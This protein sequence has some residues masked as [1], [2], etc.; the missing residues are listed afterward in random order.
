MSF[1]LSR[2]GTSRATA[3][4]AALFAL[5]LH[6]FAA[7]FEARHHWLGNKLCPTESLAS[8]YEPVDMELALDLLFTFAVCPLPI[9]LLALSVEFA[10]PACRLAYFSFLLG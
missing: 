6:H 5:P 4:R 7:G 10:L 1:I 9:I 8:Q 2:G 3:E